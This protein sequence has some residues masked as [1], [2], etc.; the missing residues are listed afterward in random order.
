MLGLYVLIV[1]MLLALL[2]VNTPFILGVVIGMVIVK[3]I[4]VAKELFKEKE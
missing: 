2:G 3:D 1:A 4:I